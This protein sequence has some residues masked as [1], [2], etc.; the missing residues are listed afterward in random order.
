MVHAEPALQGTDHEPAPSLR[1]GQAL[2]GTDHRVRA[3]LERYAGL[4]GATVRE[5]E[6]HLLE[7]DLPMAERRHFGGRATVKVA[8]GAAWGGGG[9]D[10]DGAFSTG[11][12]AAVVIRASRASLI[13]CPGRPSQTQDRARHPRNR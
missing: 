10:R 5:V 8:F 4:V 11:G 9:G 2:Q 7:I 13:P 12:E 1:S 3:V 6:P